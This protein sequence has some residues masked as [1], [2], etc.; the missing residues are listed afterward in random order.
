[1]SLFSAL[2]RTIA[3]AGLEH[4]YETRT[5]PGV[6]PSRA[7]SSV[8][9]FSGNGE[10]SLVL[11]GVRCAACLWL[12]E[13]VLRRH[14]GVHHVE[15]DVVD[16]GRDPGVAGG[17]DREAAGA[18]ERRLHPSVHRSPPI[19]EQ[20]FDGNPCF[21][22]TDHIPMPKKT[23]HS[24]ERLGARKITLGRTMLFASQCVVLIHHALDQG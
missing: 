11:E 7:P 1:M 10:A 15:D 8:P 13:Q 14:A 17:R 6:R 4:Y 9:A 23:F 24:L 12:I 16:R 21:L 19:G 20:V 5:E 18:D 3:G 22:L 2:G